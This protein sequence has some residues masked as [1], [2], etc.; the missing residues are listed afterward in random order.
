MITRTKRSKRAGISMLVLVL[1][2]GVTNLAAAEPEDEVL[3]ALLHA[4]E[5][6]ATGVGPTTIFV[7]WKDTSLVSALF[8]VEVAP[9]EV[10]PWTRVKTTPCKTTSATDPTTITS[11]L[12]N[13]CSTSIQQGPPSDTPPRFVRVVPMLATPTLTGPA[14]INV[15]GQVLFEGT[16]SAVD[17]A[18]LSPAAP[19]NV[20]C[21]GGGELAC[22]NVN[23]ITLTWDDNADNERAYWVMRAQ[24]EVNPGYGT[25]PHA[26]LSQDAEMFHEILPDFS[27]K[28]WYAIVAV[29]EEA[30]VM[31]NGDVITERATTSSASLANG[32]TNGDPNGPGNVPVDTAPLPPPT[33]PGGLTAVFTAPSTATLTW[34]DPQ[35]PISTPYVDEDGWFIEFGTRKDDMEAQMTRQRFVGQSNVSDPDPAR[36]VVTWV[37][38]NIP[39]DTLRCYR[40]RAYRASTE[41]LPAFSGYSPRTT[42]DGVCVGSIPKAP[43]NLRATALSNAAVNLIWVDNATTE[44]E[45]VVQRCP[46][47][48][49]PSSSWTTI[50]EVPT[51]TITFTDDNTLASTTYSYRVIARNGSGSSPASN[52]ATVTTKPAPLAKPLNLTAVAAG[53]HAIALA[54]DDVVGATETG[55]QIEYK[56]GSDWLDLKVL[57]GYPGADFTG[58]RPAYTDRDTLNANQTRCYRVRAVKNAGVSD[59][60]NSACATTTSALAPNGDPT[61]LTA[62]PSTNTKVT[63]SWTDNSTN[64]DRFRVDML[65][66]GNKHCNQVGVTPAQIDDGTVKLTTYAQAPG[67]NSGPHPRG[68]SFVVGGLTPHSSYFFRVTAVNGDGVSDPSNASG[69]VQTF[70]PARP[71]LLDENDQPQENGDVDAMRCE[72]KVT[73]PGSIGSE[74]PHPVGRLRIIVGASIGEVADNE[75]IMVPPTGQAS[76]GSSGLLPNGAPWSVDANGNW[77]IGY[78]FRRGPNYGIRVTSFQYGGAEFSSAEGAVR[79]MRV[80]ADCPLNYD[81]L[82]NTP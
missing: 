57:S 77:N 61:G 72:I 81:P 3:A 56:S 41:A 23:S 17:P 66:F 36:R 6:I 52:I 67:G 27:K 11:V 60:S 53:S 8:A 14:N 58:P 12:G 31:N 80:L 75:T 48:C 20:Q 76:P 43:S 69:C 51:D 37:D 9:T 40:V 47:T 46:G 64:E 18:L 68:A 54:W 35:L 82:P 10:G 50:G 55:Y 70:G 16:P 71:I 74:T 5:V 45:F 44:Q 78:K 25:T 33:D 38:K 73:T 21:N 62:S 13:R 39:P 29:R 63:L 30:I 2:F 7:Q 42:I 4:E 24:G 15:A 19:T 65:A 28:Y 59:P 32:N 26:V 34:N 22:V 79:D 1:V 49:S